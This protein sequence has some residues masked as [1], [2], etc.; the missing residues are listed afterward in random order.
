MT[1]PVSE[2]VSEGVTAPVAGPVA[3]PVSECVSECVTVAVAGPVSVAGAWC[4]RS[5]WRERPWQR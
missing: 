3:G 5:P 4:S 2:C 1:G